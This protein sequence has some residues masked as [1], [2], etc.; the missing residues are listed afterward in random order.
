[1]HK[2]I[3]EAAGK[4]WHFLDHH[5]RTSFAQVLKGTKLK[6]RD[7]DR[8]VG[9]LAREGKICLEKDKNAEMLSLVKN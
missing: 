7:A 6:P 2:G 3:G 4:I 8:A 5:G 9:W 1:M